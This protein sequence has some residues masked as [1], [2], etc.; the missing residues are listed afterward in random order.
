LNHCVYF[1]FIQQG[2]LCAVGDSGGCIT[3]L[4]LCEGLTHPQ[5]NEK[6]IIGEEKDEKRAS[7]TFS[8]T[9]RT[10]SVTKKKLFMI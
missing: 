2:N 7:G 3:L 1:K 10:S 6:N 4:Q 5:P 8:R 9:R